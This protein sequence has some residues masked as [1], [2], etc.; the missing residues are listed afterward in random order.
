MP[1]F[2]TFFLTVVLEVSAKAIKQEKE[3]NPSWKGRDQTIC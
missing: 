2:T 3:R 1:S